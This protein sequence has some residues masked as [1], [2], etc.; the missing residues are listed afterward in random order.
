MSQ[1]Q[2]GHAPT[3]TAREPVQT[4]V[5][6]FLGIIGTLVL[7]MAAVAGVVIVTSPRNSVDGFAPKTE[8]RL[9]DFRL[10]DRT[11]REVARADVA[12]KFLVVSFVFTSCSVSCLLVNQQMAE[13]QRLTAGQPDVRLLSLTV[14]PRTDTP[15]VLAQFAA[16]FG[17]DTN[18]WLFLT[19]DKAQLYGL[20]ETSFLAREPFTQDSPMP[21]GFAG[22]ERI[23]LVDRTGR[24]RRYFDGMKPTTP[25]ALTKLLSELRAE[26]PKP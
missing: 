10:T 15:P 20:I 4:D 22:T 1:P 5:K 17:A 14:D 26:H 9:A 2:P 11:G 13:V 21:G 12:G 23:A 8:R 3:P 6:V 25:A 16:R 24:V 19:G 7:I 18:R